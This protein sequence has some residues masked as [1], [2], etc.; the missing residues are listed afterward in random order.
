[1]LEVDLRGSPYEGITRS[2]FYGLEKSERE[3]RGNVIT[4]LATIPV[5]G[6]MTIA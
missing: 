4:M 6:G 3:K 2:R 5:P 1:M